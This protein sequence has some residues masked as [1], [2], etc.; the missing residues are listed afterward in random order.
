MDNMPVPKCHRLPLSRKYRKIILL[1][2]IN[3]IKGKI[4]IY[5]ISYKFLIN[6]CIYF[7]HCLLI[8]DIVLQ[9][10]Y[11]RTYRLKRLEEQRMRIKDIAIVTEQYGRI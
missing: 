6:Y 4:Y 8:S 7:Q 3:I 9:Q 1:C 10:F 5:G 11:K 2:K